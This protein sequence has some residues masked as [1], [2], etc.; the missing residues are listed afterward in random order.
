MHPLEEHQ[1]IQQPKQHQLLSLLRLQVCLIL[2]STSRIFI[3]IIR[4]LY[5]SFVS[6]TSSKLHIF[7]ILKADKAESCSPEDWYKYDGKTCGSCSALVEIKKHR[8]CDVFC[9]AQGLSCKDSWD[10]EE[11]E[12]CSTSAKKRGCGHEWTKTS[13]AI[14][15]C[16]IGKDLNYSILIKYVMHYLIK[17]LC[18]I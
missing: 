15:E 9:T 7:N 18:Q 6:R 3:T 1:I 14:C 5:F 13:D 11:D 16:E 4:Y 8:T 2:Q 12:E 10:D 17:C